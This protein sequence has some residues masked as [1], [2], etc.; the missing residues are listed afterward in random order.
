MCFGN[1]KVSIKY[2]PLKLYTN[3]IV[4]KIGVVYLLFLLVYITFGYVIRR[5]YRLKKFD[6]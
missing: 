3:A 2:E 1:L 4:G 6:I 5:I